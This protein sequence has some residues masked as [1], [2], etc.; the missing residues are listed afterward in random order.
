MRKVLAGLLAFTCSFGVA[1][2]QES[3]ACT[4]VILNR[5]N[6]VVVSGR[7]LD[8]PGELGSKIC[9]RAKGTAVADPNVKFTKGEYKPLAWTSKYDCVLVDGF[10]LPAYTDGMNS[11]GL[12][13]A[14]LWQ[15]ET[16]TAKSIKPGTEGL[17]NVTLVQYVL[18]NAKNIAEAR[19][20]I[21]KLSVFLSTYNGADML[22]HWVITEKTG[23]SVV[24]EL[25][26][27]HPQFFDEVTDVGVMT[28]SPT[29]DKQMEN[30]REQNAKRA[31]DANCTLP[32]DYRPTS[33]FVKAAYLVSTTPSLKSS[34]QGMI[35]AMQI[36]HNVEVPKGAQSSGSYTQWIVVRDQTNLK[37]WL[38]SPDQLTPIVID[39]NKVDFKS[40]ATQRIP[41]EGALSADLTRSPGVQALASPV[42]TVK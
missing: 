22:L 20:A 4:S 31:K 28:N 2:L 30:L 12:A 1:A 8:Y 29:Y 10:D 19:E 14:T 39:L 40:A 18:E 7:T 27:G 13:V 35:T 33:R 3:I 6:G 16:E 25:K 32:G 26:D 34:E 38:V 5:T 37:Y 9:F 23:R 11:E 41:V 36:L 17:A 15:D 21:S 42:V 24:V